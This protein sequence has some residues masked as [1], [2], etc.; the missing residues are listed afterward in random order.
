LHRDQYAIRCQQRRA[1]EGAMSG[2]PSM[3]T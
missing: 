1:G 3:I 2:G